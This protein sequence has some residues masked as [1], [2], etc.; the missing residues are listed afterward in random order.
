[1]SQLP[2]V[3]YDSDGV[4]PICGA[5]KKRNG[6]LCRAPAGA[7]TTHLGEGRCRRH[8]G[9]YTARRHGR[10][11]YLKR[12]SIRKLFTAHLDDPNPLDVLPEVA[13]TRALLEDYINRWKRN[14]RA[15]L[16]WY[17]SWMGLPHRGSAQLDTLTELVDDYK[18]MIAERDIELTEEQE[19]RVEAVDRLLEIM[20]KSRDG[21]P[22]E[23]LGIENAV[24]LAAEVT[25]M[26]ERIEK[27][28]AGNAVSRADM[29]RITTE[30]GR[31]VDTFMTDFG[32]Y[33]AQEYPQDASQLTNSINALK[34][35]IRA[36]WLAIRIS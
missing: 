31:A 17:E 26:V 24:T 10:Y 3:M 32:E 8:D 16:A 6:Q 18:V 11:S 1:M 19:T 9:A 25:K 36:H 33:L 35:R 34:Q 12:P 29:L 20:H 27:I 28:R 2:A 7:G 13:L 5:T 4:T 22:R 30:M 15:L 23:I 21:K 14:Q